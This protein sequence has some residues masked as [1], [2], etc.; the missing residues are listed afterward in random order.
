M[1][2][3]EPTGGEA[4]PS[5]PQPTGAEPTQ[6]PA[7]DAPTPPVQPPAPVEPTPPT[8]VPDPE[9]LPAS[10]PP[11]EPV[12]PPP[13]SLGEGPAAEE[14]APPAVA[15]VAVE[16][17]E[18][19]AREP[20]VDEPL[21]AEQVA[22]LRR[23]IDRPTLV[24]LAS[25]GARLLLQAAIFLVPVVFEPRTIDSFNLVKLTSLWVLSIVAVALW[26]PSRVGPIVPRSTIVR[27]ALVL[28][29][30]TTLATI[31]A[32]DRRLSLFGL[33]HRYEGLVSLL[34]Y[35]GLVLLIVGIY[36]Y[37]RAALRELLV[38][39]GVAAGV[40]GFYVFLQRLGIDFVSWQ[41]A[42]GG[43]P[44]RPIGNLG[45]SDFTGAFLGV[46]VPVVLY[47]ALTAANTVRRAG[48]AATGV[49]V[50]IALLFTHSG[51]MGYRAA[52]AGVLAFALLTR[53]PVGA[54]VKAALIIAGLALYLVVPLVVDAG[55]N[56]APAPAAGRPAAAPR[57]PYNVQLVGASYRMVM[58]R[59]VL[60][61]GPEG[62]Y[63]AYPE[64]R[65]AEDARL[66]GLAIADKPYNTIVA[67][68]TT[69]GIPGLLA[70]LALVGLSIVAACRLAARADDRSRL[71]A[72]A[73]G[74]MLVAYLV[75]GF[76]SVD[77][78]PLALVGWLAVAGIAALVAAED[79]DP[80][81]SEDADG[82]DLDLEA[83]LRALRA[84]GER[85]EAARAV[86]GH[87]PGRLSGV[88]PRIRAAV[89]VV[90]VIAIVVLSFRPLRA[91]HAAW[92]A[93]RVS[94]QGWSSDTMELYDKAT[95]LHPYE[96]AYQGL[97]G[98]YLERVAGDQRAPFTAVQALRYSAQRYELANAIQSG[99]V[100]F[101]L[102][103]A[104]V[105]ARLGPADPK[106]F[107]R[108]DMWLERAVA[109][110]PYD[111]Q[112]HDLY[113]EVLRS[114]NARQA[115]A[116]IAERAREEA[117]CAAALRAGRRCAT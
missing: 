49:L 41:Q 21:F 5:D 109:R 65:S 45:S 18:P 70:Y 105:Y 50:V 44:A 77:I 3:H 19:A 85:I 42:T 78:P 55:R 87:T 4:Q 108:S 84:E 28:L 59:P 83:R 9:P 10:P 112:V 104:R 53:V 110:D 106:Y 94:G 114:W 32:P 69:A 12:P 62:F 107:E 72:G 96:A 34:L 31:L 73:L 91:D 24:G 54:T 14:V 38:A 26:L 29:G 51:P 75:Q 74:A 47:L 76:R 16:T 39:M 117:A 97:A 36:R 40:V 11:A 30:I 35:V 17:E 102:N 20:K 79:D 57:T 88:N 23:S 86:T 95:K 13:P 2:D 103:I 6:P 98:F 90:V 89:A 58:D 22:L 8:E 60:G 66:R 25:K 43:A 111:P 52:M 92:A 100:Y 48:W 101:L 15:A 80:D 71:L 68:A 64:H 37:R 99:N 56:E 61:Y 27:V 33:Y 115:N 82:G 1:S 67:W 7:P 63:G 46:A 116:G 81:L 93:Q 113:A